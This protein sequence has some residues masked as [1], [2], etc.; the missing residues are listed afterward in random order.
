MQGKK[1]LCSKTV[2][3]DTTVQEKNIT[4]PLDSKQY[5]KIINKCNLIAKNEGVELRQSYKRTVKDLLIKLRFSHHP[6]KRKVAKK[7]IKKLRTL[8][9]RQV[10]DIERKLTTEMLEK[11]KQEIEL[12]K[13]VIAQKRF[14]SNKIYSLHE[15]DV[16]CIAKGKSH[17]EYEFGS[18]V[19]FATLP[20]TNVV[21]G[22]VNFQGNPNDGKTLEPTLETCERLTG[23]SFD[24][25]VVD[26]GYKGH[27]KIGDTQIIIPGQYKAKTPSQKQWYRKKCR[28]RAAIEPIIGHIK[29]DCRMIRNYL[30]GTDGDVFNAYMA[31]AAFNFRRLLRKI[32][33]EIIFVIYKTAQFFFLQRNYWIILLEI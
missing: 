18:K 28:S 12:F 27:K 22:V 26:R 5:R 11:Y 21:V 33:Q 16:A 19:S 8:A 6:R 1:D 13:R 4:F 23:L 20:G 9:G 25:A 30:K 24:Y 3:V 14:D 7:A 32:E 10:R 29:Y 15:P 17:K 2:I 31:A